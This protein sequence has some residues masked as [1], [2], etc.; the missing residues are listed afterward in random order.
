ME[1]TVVEADCV[2]IYC[3]WGAQMKLVDTLEEVGMI[4]VREGKI[5]KVAIFV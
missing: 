3:Y 1:R 5:V 2:D 4:E